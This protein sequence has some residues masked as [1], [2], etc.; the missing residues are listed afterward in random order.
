MTDL[1]LP[2]GWVR[3]RVDETGR[4]HLGRQ[5]SPDRHSGPN[6]RPYLRVANVFEDRIDT[7]DVMSMDFSPEEF[8]RYRLH[9]GDVL[10]NEGRVVD[11]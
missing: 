11:V 9:P 5:R 7:T 1:R 4:V 2:S 10:L 3:C 8:E 6:M